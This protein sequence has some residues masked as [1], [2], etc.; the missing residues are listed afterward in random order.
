MQLLD[1]SASATEGGRRQRQTALF[2]ATLHSGVQEL[3]A[4]SLRDP[5]AIGMA[6]AASAAEAA[7]DAG[8]NAPA[9]ARYQIP[10]TLRQRFVEVPCK[11]RCGGGGGG[12]GVHLHQG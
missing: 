12:T 6:G 7:S 10:H 1:A 9:G 4:L 8:P 11:L 5:V 3:V 2:S